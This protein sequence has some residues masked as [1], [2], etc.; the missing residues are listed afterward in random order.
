L[1]FRKHKRSADLGG[2][3]NFGFKASFK[4][5]DKKYKVKVKPTM[6]RSKAID[7]VMFFKQ[8]AYYESTANKLYNLLGYNTDF[9]IY[10]DD[11]KIK[12]DPKLINIAVSKYAN[13]EVW[14][15]NKFYKYAYLKNGERVDF[16]NV[17]NRIVYT[18][19]TART[20]K[21]PWPKR[22]IEYSI[23]KKYKNSISEISLYG[24]YIEYRKEKT[25]RYEGWN[26]TLLSH[27]TRREVRALSIID[28]WLNSPENFGKNSFK[29]SLNEKTSEMKFV[30]TDVGN[31]F[32]SSFRDVDNDFGNFPKVIKGVFSMGEW[33]G[34]NKL[35]IPYKKFSELE[36]EVNTFTF[37]VFKEGR[38]NIP[39]NWEL[40]NEDQKIKK[41]SEDLLFQNY[42]AIQSLNTFT[43]F[44]DLKFGVRLI[45]RLTQKQILNALCLSGLGYAGALLTTEKL[46]KRRDDLVKYFGLDDEIKLLRPN[47]V[48]ENLDWSGDGTIEVRLKDNSLKK[49]KI[50]SYGH[51]VQGGKFY[52]SF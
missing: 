12:F 48:N 14:D 15:I 40:L 33:E 38:N 46:I 34:G 42:I 11:I 16:R 4:A 21:E 41:V 39:I 47:G 31:I 52:T 3:L 32:S 30:L 10:C 50:S 5:G 29:L 49:V 8:E 36:L 25:N 22:V 20:H 7:S 44:S 17:I 51:Y 18:D 45:A 1:K 43:R 37:S 28:T 2:G 27:H 13:A 26:R 6:V 24:A 19:Q 23:K 9:G 35:L